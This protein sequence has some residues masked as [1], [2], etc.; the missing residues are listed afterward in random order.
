MVVGHMD[1]QSEDQYR[2]RDRIRGLRQGFDMKRPLIALFVGLFIFLPNTFYGYD[3]GVPYE[4][5]KNHDSDIF[6]FLSY[7]FLRPEEYDWDER[8]NQTKYP[9]GTEG[10]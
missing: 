7:D 6:E 3:A 8:N 2:F 4:D 10:L 5:K 1:A 9:D